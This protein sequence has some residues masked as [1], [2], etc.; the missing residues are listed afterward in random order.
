MKL[1][2][3]ARQFFALAR[4]SLTITLFSTI[5][6]PLL[7]SHPGDASSCF[8]FGPRFPPM[9]KAY[10]AFL[11]EIGEQ[12]ADEMGIKDIVHRGVYTCLGGPNFETV[13]ELRMLRMIGV[14]AVGQWSKVFILQFSIDSLSANYSAAHSI[15]TIAILFYFQACL[16]FMK[17]SLPGTA[18]WS[19]LLSVWSRINAAPIMRITKKRITKKWWT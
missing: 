3:H 6:K 8:R 4:T 16:R 15:S 18:T 12:V 17:W 13:A 2:E 19:S 7:S 5:Q 10:N 1:I 9:N 11:L 14:D